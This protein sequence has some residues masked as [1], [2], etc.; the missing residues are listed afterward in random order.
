MSLKST[1]PGLSIF[2]AA[3]SVVYLY[4][5]LHSELRKSQRKVLRYGCSRSFKVSEIA[6][7]ESR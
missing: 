7:N 4:S 2:Y 3:D 6:T 5:L 1:E